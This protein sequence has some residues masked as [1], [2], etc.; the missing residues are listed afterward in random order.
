MALNIFKCNF[1]T[2]LDF[3]GL[4]RLL[5]TIAGSSYLLLTIRLESVAFGRWYANNS[6]CSAVGCNPA[7]YT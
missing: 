4:N 6:I 2:A 5:H 1:L 3:K 7:C